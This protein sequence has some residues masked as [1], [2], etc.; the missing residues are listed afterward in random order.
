MT[1][2]AFGFGKKAFAGR[3]TLR[4]GRKASGKTDETS[5]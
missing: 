3:L 2:S 5:F 1:A 4:I